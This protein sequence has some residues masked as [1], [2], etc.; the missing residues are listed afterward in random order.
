MEIQEKSPSSRPGWEAVVRG[1]GAMSNK[2]DQREVD[3]DLGEESLL[4]AW[5]GSSSEGRGCNE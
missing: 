4:S 1:G 3:G 5:M 2:S